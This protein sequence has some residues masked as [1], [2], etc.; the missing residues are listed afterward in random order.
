MCV[1]VCV[2]LWVCEYVRVYAK[3]KT[4]DRSDFKLGT[5]VVLETVSKLIYF[6]FHEVKGQGHAES[7]FRTIG[8]SCHLANKTD[9]Y[10]LRKLR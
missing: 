8:T 9:Y 1:C 3:T 7:L 4:R 2:C 5:I 6:G 10:R